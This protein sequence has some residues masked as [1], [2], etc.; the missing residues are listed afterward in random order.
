MRGFTCWVGSPPTLSFSSSTARL[1][2]RGFSFKRAYLP[3]PPHVEN[4]RALPA[5][6]SSTQRSAYAVAL[7][8]SWDPAGVRT[9]GINLNVITGAS[10]SRPF[11]LHCGRFQ[12][13]GDE[14]RSAFFPSL[15]LA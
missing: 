4:G 11:N 6:G 8:D 9:V 7:G 15:S 5:R 12:N 13:F 3:H 14:G 10:I 1:S 2:V